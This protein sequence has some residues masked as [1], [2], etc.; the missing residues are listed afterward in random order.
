MRV[1]RRFSEPSMWITGWSPV[2]SAP[3][4]KSIAHGLPWFPMVSSGLLWSPV[5]SRGLPWSSAVFRGLPWFPAISPWSPVVSR[6]RFV[7]KGP[8][9]FFYTGGLHH[10]IR[11]R[12]SASGLPVVSRCLIRMLSILLSKRSHRTQRNGPTGPTQGNSWTQT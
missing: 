1:L 4:P 3:D 2:V 7:C 11:N 9:S 12:W 6:N 5:V 8:I 10:L